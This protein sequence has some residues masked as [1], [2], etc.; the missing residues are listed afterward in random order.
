MIFRLNDRVSPGDIWWWDNPIKKTPE[1]KGCHLIC[2]SRP[3]LILSSDKNNIRF[4]AFTSR[5]YDIMQIQLYDRKDI[6][7]IDTND[8][9]VVVKNTNIVT[10]ALY[11]ENSSNRFTNFYGKLNDRTFE[12]IKSLL[13]TYLSGCGNVNST[14]LS[15]KVFD[16]PI[17]KLIQIGNRFHL[18]IS[19]LANYLM[20]AVTCIQMPVDVD[21]GKCRTSEDIYLSDDKGRLYKVDFADFQ[22]VKTIDRYTVLGSISNSILEVFVHKTFQAFQVKDVRRQSTISELNNRIAKLEEER[23]ITFEKYKALMAEEEA[24]KEQETKPLKQQ[25]SK[26]TTLKEIRKKLITNTQARVEQKTDIFQWFKPVRN[27]KY[28]RWIRTEED[29][30]HELQTEQHIWCDVNSCG[31]STWFYAHQ[32]VLD[33]IDWEKCPEYIKHHKP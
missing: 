20:G 12:K 15:Y 28:L 2:G 13:P 16:P 33:S 10:S 26:I 7:H 1:N 31:M 29:I 24:K 30:L 19:R 25:L 5:R 18:V 17:G 22:N 4:V 14:K 27:S 21:S 11:R 3:V 32:L 23:A 8:R 9:N 6:D